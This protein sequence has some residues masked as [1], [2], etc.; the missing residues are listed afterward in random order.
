MKKITYTTLIG[1]F[2]AFAFA[3]PALAA[4]TASLSP[5]TL[6]AVPGQRIDVIIS[7][8]PQGTANY[9]EKLEINYP[10]D[11][12]EVASFA[13]SSNW[14]ALTQSGYDSV[15]NT[16]G[17]LVKTAGYP[18]GITAPTVFGTVSFTAKKAGNG[19]I[20]IGSTSLAFEASGQTPIVGSGAS[21][22]ITAPPVIAPVATPVVTPK[23]ATPAPTKTE[24]KTEVIP[25]KTT[26]PSNAE[27]Q[28]ATVSAAIPL[29]DGNSS[30][31]IFFGIIAA[32]A[33]LGYAVFTLRNK[34]KKL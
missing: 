2:G 27:S 5:A 8:N 14:M 6:N 26:A 32:L 28:T 4:T 22:T 33:L 10:A 30:V 29:S 20:K 13:Y 18:G 9:A 25:A 1:I 17:V 31:W 7:V 12:L 16:N 34:Q 11:S 21:F 19:M 24:P 15:D 23:K 3:L